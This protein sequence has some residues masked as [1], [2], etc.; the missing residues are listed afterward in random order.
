MFNLPRIV[1][2]PLIRHVDH[3]EAIG[4]TSDRALE[5]AARDDVPLPLLVLADRQT[6]G[7]GR[8]VNRWWSAKGAL[9]F[10]LALDSGALPAGQQPTVALATG[11]AVCEA[12]EQLAPRAEWRVKW[13]NDVMAD[14]R[15]ACGILCESVPGWPQRLVVGVGINV[16]NS[17]RDRR[18]EVGG[19][20]S[21]VR[22]QE[23]PPCAVALVDLDGL[24]R[25]L[26][27]VLLAVLDRC[28][29]RL[30]DLTG[31]G[32][33]ALAGEYRQRCFLTGRTLL[34]RA[35]SQQVAGRCRGIDDR[36]SLVL[37]TPLGLR[38][39]IAGSIDAWE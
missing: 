20:K 5:L 4:S 10:S 33:A 26:T 3:H 2:T 37:A 7:R 16:N 13:P 22:S 18:S 31:G 32:F 23:V 17:P 30:R 28:D 27:D 39:L 14:G 24:A 12:L 1:N 15:K 11:L 34:A 21:A 38:T 25:D 35:G 29:L 9:T 8:G 36:G 6:S 19:Q